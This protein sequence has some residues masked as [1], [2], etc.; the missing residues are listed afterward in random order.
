MKT[1]IALLRGINVSGKNKIAMPL[2]KEAFEKLGFSDVVTYINSGNVVFTS[3]VLNKAELVKKCEDAIVKTFALHIPVKIVPAEELEDVLAHAPA[4]WG[5]EK[6][7]VHYAM[8]VIE[9]TT[10]ED[11]FAE[12]GAIKPEYEQIAHYKDVIFWSAARKTFNKSQ[13]SKIASSAVNNSVTI[14][15]ANTANKLLQLTK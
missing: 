10:I 14:R 7:I 6:D 8:F 4:W 13:W 2:L 5:A 12:M 11:V 15:N 1:Y 3:S 9:P